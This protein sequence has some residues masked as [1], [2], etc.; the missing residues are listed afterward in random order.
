MPGIRVRGYAHRLQ[1]RRKAKRLGVF[2]RVDASLADCVTGADLV[3]LATPLS[4]FPAIFEAMA[5]HVPAGCLVTDVGSTKVWPHRWAR[6]LPR[7]V[8]YIGSHPMAGSEQQGLEYARDDLFEGA[9]TI[10]TCRGSSPPA[11]VARI[12]AFWRGLGCR[13]RIMTPAA[14]DRAVAAISHVPHAA[15]TALVN[16]TRTEHLGCAGKGFL[17]TSRVASGPANV[18]CDIFQTNPDPVIRGI[19]RLVG[20]LEKIKK[21]V[22]AGHRGRLEQLLDR[23][24]TRRAKLIQDMLNKKELLK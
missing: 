4:T 16:A 10:I 17:D 21:A 7:G 8:T 15:A 6:V 13:T 3:I 1:T 9:V 22:A 24:R 14:H 23:G 5:S 20:E 18:W 11:A 12:E 2:D 19:D